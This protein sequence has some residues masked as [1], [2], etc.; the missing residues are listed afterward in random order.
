MYLFFF[1]RNLYQ[2]HFIIKKAVQ[3]TD[4]GIAEANR[5]TVATL[6]G[7]QRTKRRGVLIF[8]SLIMLLLTWMIISRPELGSLAWFLPFSLL[9]H[10]VV[11]YYVIE[12]DRFFVFDDG[13]RRRLVYFGLKY[14]D[15]QFVDF[16]QARGAGLLV[17]LALYGFVITTF[18]FTYYYVDHCKETDFVCRRIVDLTPFNVEPTHNGKE[19][20]GRNFNQI[21]PNLGCDNSA[22]E[23]PISFR[24]FL[25][26]LYFSV[27]TTTTVGYGD[28]SPRSVTAVLLVLMHHLIA[29]ALLIGVAGQVAGV[30][31]RQRTR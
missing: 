23:C 26:Y 5:K 28:I 6:A 15:K 30:V 1:A 8:V 20:A 18:A 4:K 9:L 29:I 16:L 21:S 17:F 2:I 27:V 22:P 31:A 13:Q 3:L 11:N 25:P 19:P 10:Y 7:M 12:F 14:L 24:R